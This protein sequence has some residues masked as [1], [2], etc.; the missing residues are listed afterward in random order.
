MEPLESVMNPVCWYNMEPEESIKAY[1]E[2]CYCRDQ[3]LLLYF[4]ESTD[5]TATPDK[6]PFSRN[7]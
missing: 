5:G 7:M 2:V 1:I 3:N 6:V 4:C